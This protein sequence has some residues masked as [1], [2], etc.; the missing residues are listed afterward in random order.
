[1]VAY[2]NM[3]HV[4]KAEEEMIK[5]D[6]KLT[7]KKQSDSIYYV[8]DS[9]I[10]ENINTSAKSNTNNESKPQTISP[11]SMIDFKDPKNSKYIFNFKELRRDKTLVDSEIKK[12]KSI[13][14]MKN[15]NFTVEDYFNALN[16]NKNNESL[17]KDSKLIADFKD[18]LDND[19]LVLFNFPE[20]LKKNYLKIISNIYYLNLRKTQK[21][22]KDD[23]V[24]KGFDIKDAS[25]SGNVFSMNYKQFLKE[26]RRE[27]LNFFKVDITNELTPKI[28]LRIFPFYFSPN[29]PFRISYEKMN[30]EVNLIIKKMQIEG[31]IDE[32]YDDKHPEA[33]TK[34]VD[35][36]IDFEHLLK[37]VSTKKTNAETT[38]NKAKN[39]R[40]VNRFKKVY[41]NND[42]DVKDDQDDEEG[43]DINVE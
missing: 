17:K 20:S 18:G 13:K 7:E 6:D 37:K 5:L 2:F 24:D 32:L 40:T 43:D 29:N 11:T 35:N 33:I 25:T 36:L 39:E 42:Q 34:P 3:S 23:Y 31:C 14:Y 22:F 19:K 30:N 15:S 4:W 28:M 8:S 38:S 12:L 9:M 16:V 26:T 10:S 41:G 27:V 21:K 1:M